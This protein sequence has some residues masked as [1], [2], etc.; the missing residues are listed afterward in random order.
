MDPSQCQNPEPR[1]GICEDLEQQEKGR[2]LTE[3]QP[4]WCGVSLTPSLLH[5]V[6]STAD[7]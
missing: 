7:V 6:R 1:L 5:P 4:V 2:V 3:T